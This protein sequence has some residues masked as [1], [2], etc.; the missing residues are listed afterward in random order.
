MTRGKTCLCN[1]G[2]SDEFFQF[3]K[4]IGLGIG[5]D[6]L[7]FDKRFAGLFAR[8]L[9]ISNEILIEILCLRAGYHFNVV[10]RIGSLDIGI[11]RRNGKTPRP[12]S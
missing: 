3:R 8:H 5:K 7:A 1:I 4:P 12:L 10:A 2:N 9:Q 6:Q 11:Y